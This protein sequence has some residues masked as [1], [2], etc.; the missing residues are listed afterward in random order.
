TLR[1]A[2]LVLDR[3]VVAVAIDE[4]AALRPALD[5]EDR[6]DEERVVADDVLRLRAALEP[7]GPA[8]EQ[9]RDSR[10]A[11]PCLDPVPVHDRRVAGGEAARVARLRGPEQADAER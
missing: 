9:Q 1:E 3:V 7:A 6:G 8:R 5:G 4:P 11:D 2:A 10:N